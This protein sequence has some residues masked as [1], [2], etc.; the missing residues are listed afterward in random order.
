VGL[1]DYYKQF[2]EI[3]ESEF[4]AGLRARRAQEKALALERVPLLDLS[5]T[6]WP[7]LPHAE[8]VGASVYQAR[9]RL[10][11]SPDPDAVQVC[12]LL[13]ERHNIRSSQIVLGNGATELIATAAYVLTSEGDE[14]VA[15]HP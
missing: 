1:L 5:A 7:E 12:R 3:G 6:D 9:G 4:N 14:I 15:P 8:V 2:E 13:A 10:N 11:S